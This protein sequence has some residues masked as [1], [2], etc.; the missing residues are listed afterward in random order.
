M[1]YTEEFRK[2]FIMMCHDLTC[3]LAASDKGSTRFAIESISAINKVAFLDKFVPVVVS[4]SIDVSAYA[5][6]VENQ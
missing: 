5:I 4:S 1:A 6:R 2:Y 3:I